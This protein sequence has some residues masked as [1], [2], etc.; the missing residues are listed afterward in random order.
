MTETGTTILKFFLHISKEEQ[1]ERFQARLDVPEKNWKFAVEDL[2]T[3]ERWDDYMVAYEDMLNRCTTEAAPWYA[4]PADQKWYRNLVI[5]RVI[6]DALKQ[7]DPQY[8]PPAPGLD[9]VQIP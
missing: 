8:P 7:I 9:E 5:T 1:K 4:I 6:V 2:A 3:R